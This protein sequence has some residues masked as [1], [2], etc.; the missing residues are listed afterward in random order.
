[1]T[2]SVKD[3][4]LAKRETDGEAVELPG[5]GVKVR[6]RGLTRAEALRVVGQEMT[7][8]ESERKLLALALVDP[9]MT[10]DDVRQWQKVAPAGELQPVEEAIRRLSGLGASVVKE[11]I[12][13]FPE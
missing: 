2:D 13:R 4:L 10:E 5:L 3:L 1:M 7:A 8:A 12:Q 9:V 6:V 11:E